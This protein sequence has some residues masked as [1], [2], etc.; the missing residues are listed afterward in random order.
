MRARAERVRGRLPRGADEHF[1]EDQAAIEGAR[2]LPR[3]LPARLA[4]APTSATSPCSTRAG[5]RPAR[6]TSPRCASSPRARARS[7]SAATRRRRSASRA[8]MIEAADAERRRFGRDL[9]TARSS[10]CSP[11]RTSHGGAQEGPT[12]RRAAGVAADE[13]R[14][15]RGAARARARAASRSRSPTAG[16][17]RR[18]RRSRRLAVPVSR[19][20]RGAAAGRIAAAAYFVVAECLTNALRYGRA[21]GVRVCVSRA[22]T[23]SCESRSPTTASAGPTPTAAPA[24]AGSPTASTCCAAGSRCTARPARA[25]RSGPPPPARCG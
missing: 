6:R 8:R 13:L 11:S 2:E 18:S 17:R 24:C 23:A 21:T 25:R 4:R 22:T 10:A 12:A 14:R 16:S 20:L 3:G 5:W 19:G 15:P 9:T 7:S 1:P